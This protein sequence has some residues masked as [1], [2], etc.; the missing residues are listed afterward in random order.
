MKNKEYA[1][2]FEGAVFYADIAGFTRI[3]QHLM[4]MGSIG[5]ERLSY[6]LDRFYS[7]FFNSTYRNRGFV[8]CIEGDSFISIF[9]AEFCDIEKAFVDIEKAFVKTKNIKPVFLKKV[10]ANIS[11]RAGFSYGKIDWIIARNKFQNAFF[12]SGDAVLKAIKTGSNSIPGKLNLEAFFKEHMKNHRN[13]QGYE[14]NVIV[15]SLV[16][17]KNDFYDETFSSRVLRKKNLENEFRD[18]VAV[19]IQNSGEYSVIEFVKKISEITDKFDCYTR[20]SRGDKGFISVSVFGAPIRKE[21]SFQRACDFALSISKKGSFKTGMTLGQSFTGLIGNQKK[22]EYVIVGEKINLAARLMERAGEC[23]I[24]VDQELCDF[25]RREYVFDFVGEENFKGINGKVKFWSLKNSKK[26]EILKTYEFIGMKELVRK[27]TTKIGSFYQKGEFQILCMNGEEGSGKSTLVKKVLE[28]RKIKDPVFVE[29]EKSEAIDFSVV[30]KLFNNLFSQESSNGKSFEKKYKDILRKTKNSE[31]TKIFKE[32]K[33]VKRDV[34][35]FM[36]LTS[37]HKVLTADMDYKTLI[38]RAVRS[39]KAV[40]RGISLSGKNILIIENAHNIDELSCRILSEVIEYSEN[41]KILM[42]LISRHSG[43]LSERKCLS[44]IEQKATVIT[45]RNLNKKET[46]N[47]INSVLK[48]NSSKSLLD[49]IYKATNGNPFFI[50]TYCDYL[51]K[52]NWISTRSS[53]AFLRTD[54]KSLPVNIKDVI[55]AKADELSSSSKDLVLTCSLFIDRID[56]KIISLVQ[57]T[58]RSE[59]ENSVDELLRK[60]FFIRKEK[61]F[62]K[63]KSDVVSR[64]LN[65]IMLETDK[66][67]RHE[68]I[69]RIFAEERGHKKSCF[70]TIAHHFMGA[71]NWN[72]SAEWSEKAGDYA[73]ERYLYEKALEMYEK[74]K[75]CM[76]KKRNQLSHYRVDLKIS[77]MAKNRGD[78]KKSKTILLGVVRNLKREHKKCRFDRKRKREIESI[79]S[80][81]IFVLSNYYTVLSQ[82]DRSQDTLEIAVKMNLLKNDK[83]KK[84]NYDFYTG[85]N[86]YHKNDYTKAVLY[87]QKALKN[88]AVKSNPIFMS[89]VL[90][91]LANVF[92]DKGE[93][94]KAMYYYTEGLNVVA[95]YKENEIIVSRIKFNIAYLLFEKKKYNKSLKYLSECLAVYKKRRLQN[96]VAKIYLNL[97]LLYL[98]IPDYRKSKRYLKMSLNLNRKFGEMLDV[99]R[100]LANLGIL[101]INTKSYKNAVKYF[102]EALAIKEKIGDI[103]GRGIVLGNLADLYMKQS[104]YKEAEKYSVE[105]EN[106]IRKLK[107]KYLLLILLSS[108]LELYLLMGKNSFPDKKAYEILALADELKIPEVKEK[109][110]ENLKK[111]SNLRPG[112]AKNR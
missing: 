101:M 94:D 33:E 44:S 92:S 23:E 10:C 57:E 40:L 5:A 37:T 9:P 106:I 81:S 100:V 107:L 17:N 58:K 49:F 82:F 39:L 108:Q 52:N 14:K 95:K 42:I 74:S 18:V 38:S 109:A 90:S 2:S 79:L 76:R 112:S 97:G 28:T 4:A 62:L 83:F 110:V 54:A 61:H 111:F 102:S 30:T 29:L 68:K 96:L 63:M 46:S 31:N 34:N 41:L 93:Y 50:S 11:A 3:T 80:D 67:R 8:S 43:N 59:F 77:E 24:L 20:F 22:T 16:K 27:L 78:I 86:Y 15:K 73:K 65:G 12:C 89:Q 64:T 47:L 13:K 85:T 51:L 98:N 66:K 36:F 60:G 7:P 1:G 21:G 25:S 103:K 87:L 6:L 72:R 32:L 55:V 19:F 45:V 84:L 53:T 91:N 69:A 104:K 70:E 88:K 75:E 35:Y 71:G 99:S 56:E 26:P 48:V 105:A